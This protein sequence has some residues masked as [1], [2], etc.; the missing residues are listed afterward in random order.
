LRNFDSQR[1]VAVR[2]MIQT[3]SLGWMRQAGEPLCQS[4]YL[5]QL[6]NPSYLWLRLVHVGSICLYRGRCPKGEPNIPLIA[7][8]MG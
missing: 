5:G 7:D 1:Q 6:A 4:Q 8:D 2:T 3:T